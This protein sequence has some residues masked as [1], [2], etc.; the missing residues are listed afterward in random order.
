M[1][2]KKILKIILLV[3]VL[4]DVALLISKRIYPKIQNYFLEK[5][6]AEELLQEKSKYTDEAVEEVEDNDA[7]YVYDEYTFLETSDE[8]TR[9]KTYIGDYFNYI[10]QEEYEKAYNLLY[11]GFKDNY[12]N[13]LEEFEEYVKTT[14]PS[15]FYLK[16]GEVK[17][18]GYYYY[19]SVTIFDMDEITKEE[20]SYMKGTIFVLKEND[21]LDFVL[22][23][24]L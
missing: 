11:S 8:V 7:E 3:I 2:E 9:M 1:K 10:K 5:E 23:F 13:S 16:Y 22:S 12:F 21:L 15:S 6:Y 17:R 20:K 4:L 24:G 18:Y 19:V 14:Y